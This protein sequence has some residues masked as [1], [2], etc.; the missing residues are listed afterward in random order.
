MASMADAGLCSLAD[1]DQVVK[2]GYDYVFGLK[3][4]QKLLFAE[5]QERC[6]SIIQ[7]GCNG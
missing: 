2:A 4:N 1:A 3:G 6:P 5:A 7:L